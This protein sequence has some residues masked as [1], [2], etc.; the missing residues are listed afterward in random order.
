VKPGDLPIASSVLDAGAD[1]RVLESLL[2]VGPLAI[3]SIVVLGR[4]ALTEAL[5]VAYLATFVTY[6]LYRGTR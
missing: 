5:A 2:L 4:S 1:D 3:G 6:A